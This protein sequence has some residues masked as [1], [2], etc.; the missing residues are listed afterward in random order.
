MRRGLIMEGGAMRG[1]FTAGVIDVLMENGIEFDGAIGVSAGATFGCNYKSKQIG[2]T[3]RYNLQYCEDYR[4][5]SF[6]SLIKNGDYFDNRFCY[7]D[8]PYRLDPFDTGTFEANPMEFYVVATD[9]KNGKPVYRKLKDGGLEDVEWIRASASI[10]L[11]SKLVRL[12]EKLLLDGGASDSVPLRYFESIGY[13]RNVV[14]LTRPDDYRK[15]RTASMPL[16][17]LKYRSFPKFVELMNDRHIRYNENIQYVRDRESAGEAFVIRP[18]KLLEL[19]NGEKDPEKLKKV[20]EV[21]RAA[22]L[23]AVN[24]RHLKK[25]LEGDI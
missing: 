2:R 15:S 21:G 7:Y 14:I 9:V 22:G 1:I 5:G 17:K 25:W 16:I 12:D 18:D 3:I 11:L 8:I 10:P 24:E 20:Y 6:R 13:D 4:Y 23:E 19:S